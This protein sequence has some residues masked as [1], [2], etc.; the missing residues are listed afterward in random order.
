MRHHDGHATII[1][2]QTGDT[3]RR[4]VRVG[5]I[6]RG[7]LAVVVDVT[8]CDL[9]AALHLAQVSAVAELG[10]PFAMRDGDRQARAFHAIEEQRGALLDFDHRDTGLELLGLVAHE[11]RPGLGTRDQLLELGEHLA[12]V[13]DAQ[14]EAV[15]TVEEALE[16]FTRTRI[17]QHRLGPATAS[18]QHV[19]VGEAATGDQAPHGVQI[20]TPFEDVA[21]V[22]IDGLETG[23][24][25]AC[26]HLEL[27]ID[28]LLAQ[29]RHA[30][31][32]TGVQVRRRDVLV[33]VE[34]GLGGQARVTHVVDGLEFALGA[35]G[36]VT[37]GLHAIAGLGP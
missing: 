16:L 23:T 19:T 30:R 6:A 9:A 27:T 37:R 33:D 11:A 17:E 31:T 8:Q 3:G 7:G 1:G 32:C 21:H 4:A 22:D 28:A 14:R 34:G 15:V 5:R 36:V 2:G 20:D 26:R 35:I 25:E 24:V 18:A 13:A 10:T 12:T 29:D